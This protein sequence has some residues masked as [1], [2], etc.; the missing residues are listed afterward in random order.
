MNM[1]LFK[2]IAQLANLQ[3]DSNVSIE[4]SPE[5]KTKRLQSLIDAGLCPSRK[6]LYEKYPQIPQNDLQFREGEDPH[7]KPLVFYEESIF[8][9]LGEY[10]SVEKEIVIFVEMCKLAA[11]SLGVGVDVLIKVV[12]THEVAHAVTHWQCPECGGK[13]NRHILLDGIQ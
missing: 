10:R 13:R 3:Y 1:N 2:N 7:R 11:E 4:K 9:L 12:M 6:R 5:R 8:D